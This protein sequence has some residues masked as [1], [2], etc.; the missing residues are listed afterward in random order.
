MSME[1]V[2][3]GGTLIRRSSPLTEEQFKAKQEAEEKQ[4]ISTR[5]PP[6]RSAGL[7]LLASYANERNSTSRATAHRSDQGATCSRPSA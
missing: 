4:R 7:A 2:T 3:R 5:L 1:E 6:S